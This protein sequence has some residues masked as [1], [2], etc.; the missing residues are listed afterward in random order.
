MAPSETKIGVPDRLG[1]ITPLGFLRRTLGFGVATPGSPPVSPAPSAPV[2]LVHGILGQE[3]FYWNLL[4]RRL[5]GAGFDVHEL[6]LPNLALGDLRDA[7]AA[8]GESFDWWRREHGAG[9]VD[10]V[11]HSAGGLVL[12]HHLKNDAQ[13]GAVRRLIT[14]GTP[15]HG[16]KVAHLLPEVGMIGQVREGSE[17]LTA[18]NDG[19]PTPGPAHYT[20]FWTPFDGVVLPAQSARLPLRENVEN[21]LYPGITHWGYLFGPR[22]G[23][24]LA[25]ELRQGWKG[26][27]RRVGRAPSL[28]A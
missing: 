17:F 11:A 14:L 2:V 16:T 3:V 5:A 13:D 6:T 24:V 1:C 10:I 18:L 27:E 4:R 7:A 15:H 26:G 12:R 8:F 20:A 9:K 23:R 28:V 21:I 25:D 22:M 19:D